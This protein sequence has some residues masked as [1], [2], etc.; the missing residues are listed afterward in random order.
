MNERQ[1]LHLTDSVRE[2]GLLSALRDAAAVVVGYSGGADSS[3]LLDYLADMANL[4]EY[5]PVIAV[6]VNHML[7]GDD[8]DSDERF[9]R[10]HCEAAGIPFCSV[11]ADV[12]AMMAQS[13]KGAEECARTARYKILD[14]VRRSIARGELPQGYS[15]AYDILSRV[16]ERA[17]K[18][19]IATA[20]NADDNLETVI[21]NLARG[22]GASG[23]SGIPPMRDDGV[24]RPLLGL[25]SDEIRTMCRECGI[26]YVVDKTNADTAYTRNY[27]R[28]EIVPAMRGL[29]TAVHSAVLRAGVSLRA[30][31]AYFRDA[32]RRA[33]GDSAAGSCAPRGV[34]AAMETPIL[35]RAL[36]ILMSNVTD[37]AMGECHISEACRLITREGTG[38]LSLPD[39]VTLEVSK[40]L[41]S[42]GRTLRVTEPF[43]FEIILPHDGECVKY[44]CPEAGFD[45]YFYKNDA[46]PP[47]DIQN[48]Y[49]LFIHTETD[50]DTIYGRVYARQKLPGDRLQLGCTHRRVKKMLCDCGVPLSERD[51][52][53]VIC[54]DGGAFCI[55]YLP[56]R[57]T[58]K[59][60]ANVL[61]ILYCVYADTFQ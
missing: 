2:L 19:L 46:A 7:R 29:S 6:H 41:V 13:G 24:I 61:H 54:D 43:S 21:F 4:P 42:F 18:V 20:H 10:N 25:T 8:A 28:N 16:G 48:I 15:G 57:T 47:A 14:G 12:P 9:C 52:I 17:G 37:T 34:L 32:A 45:L 26:E 36:V 44:Q 53:P 40:N 60:A 1:R 56:P 50:F 35:A 38:R 23:L 55:P 27:I 39:G 51:R 22:G 3:L 31:E 30:D 11:R 59:G 33:L 49:K 58:A 5:P